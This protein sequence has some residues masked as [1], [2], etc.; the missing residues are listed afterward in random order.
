MCHKLK[1][2]Y[3]KYLLKKLSRFL[4]D[5]IPIVG[6]DKEHEL[7][8]LVDIIC[9]H[10]KKIEKKLFY[11]RSLSTEEEGYIL[12]EPNFTKGKPLYKLDELSKRHNELVFICEG[13]KCVDALANFGCLATTSGG[14]GSEKKTDWTIL[15]KRT[16]ALWPN[17]DKAGKNYMKNVGKILHKLECEINTVDID[18]LNFSEKGDSVDFMKKHINVSIDNLYVDLDAFESELE[19]KRCRG[20][21]GFI[22]K[23]NNLDE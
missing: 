20:K 11:P 5:L 13:E 23:F 14:V 16:V 17:N 12:G 6:D 19:L 8:G 3:D 9:K 2:S 1:I 18:S 7:M 10:I 22:K 4:G 15:A 21:G